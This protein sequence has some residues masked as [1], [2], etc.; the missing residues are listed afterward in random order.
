VVAELFLVGRLSHAPCKLSFSP[1]AKSSFRLW[2]GGT[3][4]NGH[5]CAP[6]IPSRIAFLFYAS[7]LDALSC[8]LHSLRL[9]VATSLAQRCSLLPTWTRA[10]NYLRGSLAF[11]SLRSIGVLALV[12]RS[13]T[14]SSAK[15][16]SLVSARFISLHRVLRTF[17]FVSAGVSW[18]TPV[19]ETP[20]S[21]SCRI[22][23][24]PEPCSR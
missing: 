14:M 5:I 12:A 21:S 10:R 18:S 23:N 11:L 9:P 20:M 6:V 2:Q 4:A 8:L 3:F 22:A 16:R 17:S 19:T 24:L 15:Q 13:L 7:V 1:I